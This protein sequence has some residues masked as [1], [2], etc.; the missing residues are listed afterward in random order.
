[1][2][3]HG[4]FPVFDEQADISI[5]VPG[6]YITG[7]QCTHIYEFFSVSDE[8]V[9]EDAGLV[10]ISQADHVLHTVDGGGMHWLNVGG[11]LGGDPVLLEGE[12]TL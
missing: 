2:G 10:E 1:M 8:E 3:L 12:G 5:S 9:A 6:V 7:Q 4:L 11:I